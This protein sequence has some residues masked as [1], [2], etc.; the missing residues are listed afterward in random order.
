MTFDLSLLEN[1]LHQ[2]EG[3]ALDFKEEQYLFENADVRSKAELLKDILALANSWRLTTAYIL[4][5]VKEVK[6]GRSEIIGVESHLDD[7]NLHQFVNGKTQRPV[8]FSYLPFRTGDGEVGAIQIPLQ[9]RPA[10][11]KRR[12]GGIDQNE[13]W[14][15]DGSST[16]VA[17]P[18]EIARMGAEQALS[19]TPQFILDWADVDLH[20]ILR[21]PHAVH[22]LVLDPM[23]PSDTFARR[24]PYG[25][26]IDPFANRSYSKEVIICAAE[27]NFLT[28]LGFRLHNKSGT[29]G[30]RIR[31]TG[32]VTKFDG[33]VIREWID[34]VP[35]PTLN[36]FSSRVPDI[37]LRDDD[38]PSLSVRDFDNY[39]EVVI[40]F[41]D[42]RPHD[43]VWTDSALFVGST[44]PGIVQ[45]RGVLRGDNL[46]DPIECELEVQMGVECRPMAIDDVT[47]YLGEE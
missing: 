39:W 40:D 25:L 33:L 17:S 15:R 44:T 28:P 35:S 38:A 30:K 20:K 29:V 16:R 26:G 11:L 12:F 23:L 36:L 19:G 14:I 7:A 46:P 8:E 2:E 42:V 24:R 4:I 34:D 1:L 9:E 3:P 21:S 47:P 37:P 32:H 43:E 31:F 6:G 5:G 18:D 27:R 41:G 10:Y 13:V 45:L 22:S